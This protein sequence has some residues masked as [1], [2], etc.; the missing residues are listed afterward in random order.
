MFG[1]FVVHLGYMLSGATARQFTAAVGRVSRGALF[2]GHFPDCFLGRVGVGDARICWPQPVSRIGISREEVRSAVDK[3]DAGQNK[4]DS[5]QPGSGTGKSTPR[6][7]PQPAKPPT[8]PIAVIPPAPPRKPAA[9]VPPETAK[10]P[11]EPHTPEPS[12]WEPTEFEPA[13]AER[14]PRKPVSDRTK[15]LFIN[16]SIIATGLV[17][18]GLMAWGLLT[19]LNTGSQNGQASDGGTPT[20]TA[21]ASPLPLPREGVSPLDFRL[22]DCFKDFDPN[23]TGST[24][25]ACDTE[26]SAQLVAV[27]HYPESDAY[28]GQDALRTKGREI[29]QNAKLN[30]AEANYVL[31]QRTAFP[32]TTSWETGDRRVDCYVTADAGNVIKENLLP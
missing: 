13:A 16:G 5:H 22:G 4:D 27:H 9:A 30:G 21:D 7:P 2:T 20:P 6:V 15:Q 19:F 25:V 11:P 14:Q 17:L 28:P 1:Q 32:S 12:T 18:L 3:K 10:M 23:A 29:C 8:V 26:H 31:L 24:V